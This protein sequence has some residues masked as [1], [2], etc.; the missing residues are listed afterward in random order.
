[1]LATILK[2]E[3]DVPFPHIELEVI[4]HRGGDSIAGERLLAFLVF[5]SSIVKDLE[6]TA[7]LSALM[8]WVGYNVLPQFERFF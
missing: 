2:P 1:M 3:H 5:E 4:R 8:D 7:T 6:V